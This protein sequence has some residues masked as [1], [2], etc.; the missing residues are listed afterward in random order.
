VASAANGKVLYNAIPTGTRFSCATCHAAPASNFD[1]VLNG[2]N[3]P[4]R[5]AA[6]IASNAGGMGILSGKFT[7]AQLQDIAA[8]LAQPNL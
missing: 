6:A 5:I 3:D 4:A 8:Y 2:A 1:K 7:P